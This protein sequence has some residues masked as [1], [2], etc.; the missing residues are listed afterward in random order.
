MYPIFLQRETVQQF[1]IKSKKHG[2]NYIPLG[3]NANKQGK[4][5]G[6]II[7]GEK[8]SFTQALGTSMIKVCD[9]EGA[10]TGLS[11]AEAIM[12]NFDYKTVTIQ[13]LNHAHTI[14]IRSQS[15]LNSG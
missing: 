6:A 10:K 1:I 11:E 8:A 13:A 4:M 15:R 3:T 14:Q 5:A 7:C 12:E 9:M 2:N